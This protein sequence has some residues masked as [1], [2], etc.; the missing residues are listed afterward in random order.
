MSRSSPLAT[1]MAVGSLY[2]AALGLSI[3]LALEPLSKVLPIPFPSEP[4][5]ARMQGVLLIGLAVFYALPALDLER[6]L[7]VVAGA[8]VLRLL[9]GAYVIGYALTGEIAPFFYV[10]GVADLAFGF[11]H[12]WLLRKERGI[13]FIATLLGRDH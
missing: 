13:G 1:S 2:D 3:V 7:R 12:A 9:G 11:W 8:I 10:F 5:Y 6:H 4:F